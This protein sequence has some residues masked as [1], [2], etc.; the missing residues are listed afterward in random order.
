M[1]HQR[2]WEICIPS[3][4]RIDDTQSFMTF[5]FFICL[6]QRLSSFIVATRSLNNYARNFP[7][8]GKWIKKI[9]FSIAKATP[10]AGSSAYIPALQPFRL[11]ALH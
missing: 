4:Y 1:L 2:Y 7:E 5:T 3:T 10:W 9:S 6:P 8:R 11:T